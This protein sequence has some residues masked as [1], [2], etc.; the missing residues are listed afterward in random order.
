M[1]R[2]EIANKLNAALVA[3]IYDECQAIYC[4]ARI[5]K[6]IEID[7][8]KQLYRYL[9]FYCNWALHAEISYGSEPVADIL[10]AFIEERDGGRF[11]NFF[12]LKEDLADFLDKQELPTDIITNNTAFLR[13]LNIL[14]GIY[15]DTP[16]TVNFQDSKRII[17]IWKSQIPITGSS[18][19]ISY[20][21]QVKED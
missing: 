6:I 3:G 11:L 14:A 12:H 16:V 2:D 7:K 18:L 5:R 10:H 15:S 21:I 19:D 1:G 9:F 4:L 20:R 13:F 17:T 8:S